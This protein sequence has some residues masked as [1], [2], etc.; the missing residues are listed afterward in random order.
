M[1]HRFVIAQILLDDLRAVL[2]RGRNVKGHLWAASAA[3]D[4]LLLALD[5]RH[6]GD[7]ARD[8][9]YGFDALVQAVEL[10]T[11]LIILRAKALVLLSDAQVYGLLG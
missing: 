6:L 10:P 4:C 5:A 11:L 1:E 8:G 9:L 7:A 3:L 2:N